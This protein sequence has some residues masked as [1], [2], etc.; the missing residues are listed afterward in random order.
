MIAL[1]LGEVPP[2]LHEFERGKDRRRRL[3][4]EEEVERGGHEPGRIRV[5]WRQTV[6]VGLPN[7][8]VVAGQLAPEISDDDRAAPAAGRIACAA[9]VGDCSH[10]RSFGAWQRGHQYV[11]L[12]IARRAARTG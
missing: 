10:G 7:D 1:V 2:D 3:A 12:G 8:D 11:V 4:L 9:H 5:A 6:D